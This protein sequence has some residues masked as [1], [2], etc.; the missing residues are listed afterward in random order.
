MR[1]SSTASAKGPA[2]VAAIV[3]AGGTRRRR[4]TQGHGHRAREREAGRGPDG[5]AQDRV[6]PATSAPQQ[7]AASIGSRTSGC[8]RFEGRKAAVTGAGGFIGN[9]ICRRLAAE[10]AEVLGLDVDPARADRV[11]AA[12]AD[13]VEVDVADREALGPALDR[14]DLVVHT[15]ALVREWGPMDDFVRVNVAGTA[16]L[17]D[18]CARGRRGPG[19]PSELGGGLRV[20]QPPRAG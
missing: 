16:H 17:L 9:A 14:V 3:R 10:G 11:A 19:R 2:A 4:R 18:A 8:Q 20:R 1:G 7:G 13:F 12:G 15:A 6:R 5:G